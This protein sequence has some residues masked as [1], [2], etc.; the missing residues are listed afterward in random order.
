MVFEPGNDDGPNWHIRK[1]SAADAATLSLIARATFL[2]AFAD[3]IDGKAIVEHCRSELSAGTFARTLRQ[4]GLAWL[5][6]HAGTGAPIGFAQ[7]GRTQL[8][9]ATANDVE[10]KRIYILSQYRGSGLAQA[11]WNEAKTAACKGGA[12]RV[13]LAVYRHNN[14][15]RGFYEKLGFS[16]L[17]DRDFEVGGKLYPGT[18]FQVPLKEEGTTKGSATR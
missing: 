13:L 18:V 8:P 11:I 16:R 9:E 4:T 1:A 3:L 5:A 6:Q 17:D 10:L 12:G 14:R 2:E 15:A 7:L